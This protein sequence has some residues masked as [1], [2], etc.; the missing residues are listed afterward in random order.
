M[1]H[2]Q[3][4]LRFLVPQKGSFIKE[5]NSSSANHSLYTVKTVSHAPHQLVEVMHQ[6]QEEE[7]EIMFLVIM[8]EAETGRVKHWPSKS[9]TRF[10][11]S[12]NLKPSRSL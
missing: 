12:C 4:P 11:R 8:N 3:F 2:I 5:D 6:M 7:E 10:Y 1:I 9:D